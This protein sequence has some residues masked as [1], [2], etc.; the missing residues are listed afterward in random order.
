MSITKDMYLVQQN[1]Q[2][3]MTNSILSAILMYQG[4]R[5]QLTFGLIRNTAKDLYN[6]LKSKNCKTYTCGPPKSF[7]IKECALNHGLTVLG[8]FEDRKKGHL[9]TVDVGSNVDNLKC[10]SLSYYSAPICTILHLECIMILS[11]S[12]LL[13]SE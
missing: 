7:A 2:L 10:L 6:Y 3:I 11:L 8:N 4:D 5:K 9:A 13:E 12:Y 1:E